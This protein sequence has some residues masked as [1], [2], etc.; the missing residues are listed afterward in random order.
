MYVALLPFNLRRIAR[1]DRGFDDERHKPPPRLAEEDVTRL[2][3]VLESNTTITSL[4]I[5]GALRLFRQPCP[6]ISPSQLSNLP[7][8]PSECDLGHKTG[9]AIGRL[10]ERNTML[11]DIN[12]SRA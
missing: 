2:L 11:L 6:P 12:V 9:V 8:L 4:V 1:A 5:D 7:L 10:L 3:G